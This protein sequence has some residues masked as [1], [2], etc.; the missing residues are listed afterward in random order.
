MTAAL[1]EQ[2][3][4]L[5]ILTSVTGLAVCRLTTT[6][7]GL[8]APIGALYLYAAG[9]A[10][11]LL[12]A[13]LAIAFIGTAIAACSYA[14]ARHDLLLSWVAFFAV[15]LASEKASRRRHRDHFAPMQCRPCGSLKTCRPI[16]GQR[17]PMA[18]SPMSAKT[19]SARPPERCRGRFC[20][21][22]EKCACGRKAV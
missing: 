19:A 2:R 20:F 18:T 3:L 6:P 15:A 14:D 21:D 4:F 8:L 13:A 17:V 5:A 7:F 10:V 9:R 16:P 22:Y 11:L 1:P 12:R